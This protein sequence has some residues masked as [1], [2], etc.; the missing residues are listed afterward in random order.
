[1]HFSIRPFDRSKVP[2]LRNLSFA[3]KS[4]SFLVF[5]QNTKYAPAIQ[6]KNYESPFIRDWVEFSVY[7]FLGVESRD[8]KTNLDTGFVQMAK[9]LKL[10]MQIYKYKSYLLTIS[11]LRY[12]GKEKKVLFAQL[13]R[14]LLDVSNS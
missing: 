13:S 8:K 12:A 10:Y 7:C 3:R 11:R 6:L 9:K 1:M 4:T 14:T 2:E 5:G